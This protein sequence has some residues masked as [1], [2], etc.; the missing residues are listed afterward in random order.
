MTMPPRQNDPLAQIV[1]RK[2]RRGKP[3]RPQ[4]RWWRLKNE[5]PLGAVREWLKIVVPT[6]AASF[7]FL[8]YLQQSK[9]L[10][11][12][13]EQLEVQAKQFEQ[14]ARSANVVLASR[15]SSQ[16]VDI[17]NSKLALRLLDQSFNG[18]M[19]L[20]SKD[21]IDGNELNQSAIA[22]ADGIVARARKD[23][24]AV[25]ATT[26]A[27]P[28]EAFKAVRSYYVTASVIIEE[29]ARQVEA[30]KTGAVWLPSSIKPEA[31]EL[32]AKRGLP[33]AQR[34]GPFADG[35]GNIRSEAHLNYGKALGQLLATQ[36]ATEKQW[37]E[38]E[39]AINQPA[40]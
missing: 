40:R 15:L 28:F 33:L 17:E 21:F 23:R 29:L 24:D 13:G 30:L 35:L 34:I 11:V 5:K 39:K 1:L 31:A 19:S 25:E 4:G 18:L 6:V 20:H 12:Q 14:A 9:Q 32:F 37:A 16:L 22:R 8:A 3:R 26:H 38:I 7:A 27:L 36:E 2:L 10:S